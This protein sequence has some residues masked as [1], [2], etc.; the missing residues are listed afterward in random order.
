[1]SLLSSLPSSML[2]F[3]FQLM[4]PLSVLFIKYQYLPS[5]HRHTSTRQSLVS[6]DLLPSWH[7]DF[8][9][10]CVFSLN[11]KLYEGKSFIC[12]FTV[13]SSGLCK[14]LLNSHWINKW[15]ESNL[16]QWDVLSFLKRGGFSRSNVFGILTHFHFS[17]NGRILGRWQWPHWAENHL[18]PRSHGNTYKTTSE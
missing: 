1:M 15:A 17:Y 8:Y 10:V 12:S 18:P 2:K 9:S 16:C 4:A 14:C 7:D 5:E 6:H 3:T 13:I 11:F